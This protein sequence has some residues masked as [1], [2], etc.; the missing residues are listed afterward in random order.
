LGDGDP[1]KSS[2][3]LA[4]QSPECRD[5]GLLDDRF[6]PN[7]GWKTSE[8]TNLVGGFSKG[9]VHGDLMVIKPHGI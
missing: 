7:G 1:L 6:S 8:N 9:Y 2:F 5:L 3:Y 4:L